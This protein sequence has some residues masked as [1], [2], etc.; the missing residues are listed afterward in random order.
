MFF[1]S[2]PVIFGNYLIYGS[3]S[4]LVSHILCESANPVEL[5]FSDMSS[6]EEVV[7]R[8]HQFQLQT[9]NRYPLVIARGKGVFLFDL[10]GKRYLDFV[11]GLGLNAL[12]HAHPRIVKTIR[13]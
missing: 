9:Y 4:Y 6:S 1:G 10:D 13:E 2:R 7:Q 5:Y 8:E 12:G 3:V 11:A